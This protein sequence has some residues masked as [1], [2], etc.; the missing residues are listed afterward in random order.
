MRLGV[1]CRLFKE[2]SACF[3]T[4]ADQVRTNPLFAWLQLPL[5]DSTEGLHPD[6]APTSGVVDEEALSRD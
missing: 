5:E 4:N 2:I 3:R 1:H 6:D